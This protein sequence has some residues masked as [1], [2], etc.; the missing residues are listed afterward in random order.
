MILLQVLSNFVFCC[1]FILKAEAQYTESAI[2][3]ILAELL[4]GWIANLIGEEYHN[5]VID[6]L[7]TPKAVQA[8]GA[9]YRNLIDQIVEQI[10]NAQGGAGAGG[11]QGAASE[12][13]RRCSASSGT[14]TRSVDD[15][16]TAAATVS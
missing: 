11:G 7:E 6:E 8:L 1:S 13:R 14:A 9:H 4:D 10:R 15:A 16:S 3:L 5:L 12:R 2:S